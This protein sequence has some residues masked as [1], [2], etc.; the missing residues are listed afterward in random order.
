MNSGSSSTTQRSTTTTNQTPIPSSPP[1]SDKDEKRKKAMAAIRLS[2]NYAYFSLQVNQPLTHLQIQS[3]NP[4]N[5]LFTF[6]FY[7]TL[8]NPTRQ[9]YP[10]RSNKTKTRKTVESSND[11]LP[12]I[13]CTLS[14]VNS[15]KKE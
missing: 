12:Q 15:I 9:K 8:I 13:R 14:R 7:L 5:L 1:P 2:I 6:P 10:F 3:P 11:V 4:S